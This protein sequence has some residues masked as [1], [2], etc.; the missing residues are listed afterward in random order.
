M[1][2]EWIIDVLTDLRSFACK[3]GLKNLAK[4]LDD[5]RMAA[6]ADLVSSGEGKTGNECATAKAAG[7]D[8]GGSRTRL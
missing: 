1:K 2:N 5:L 8:T 3:N 6:A 4:K 7:C